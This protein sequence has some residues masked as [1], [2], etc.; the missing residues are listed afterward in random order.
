MEWYMF[1]KL[2]KDQ[3]NVR[4][5]VRISD[6][7]LV[8]IKKTGQETGK[9]LHYTQRHTNPEQKLIMETTATTRS[10]RVR[11]DGWA[12]G[13]TTQAYLCRG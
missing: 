12:I 2:Y 10:L 1:F 3:K 11:I 7:W 8:S 6:K 13:E 5:I 4:I 9:L